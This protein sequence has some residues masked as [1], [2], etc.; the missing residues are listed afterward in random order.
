MQ[1]ASQH[2]DLSDEDLLLRYKT[3]RDSEWLGILLQRY[4]MLL[5]GVAMKYLKEKNSAEEAVQQVC[6]KVLTHLPEGDILNFKGWLYVLMRNN[7]LQLLRDRTYSM[8]EEKLHDLPA[9]ESARDELRY[10]EYTIEQMN[11]ALKELN[12]EQRKSVVL[13]YLHKLSYQ[14]I[15]ERT[16]YSYMQ[17]KSFIQNG[18]R[19]LKIILTKKLG[20]HQ[21]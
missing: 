12:E 3:S 14:E 17:V 10:K 15:M 8:D 4:T 18:K 13:F 7:C 9:S 20:N 1:K 19:N 2:I 6:F 11:E 21:Q 5:F 16:G